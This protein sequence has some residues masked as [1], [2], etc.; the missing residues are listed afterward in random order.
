MFTYMEQLN[1]HKL[2]MNSM[3]YNEYDTIYN[4]YNKR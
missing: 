2:M 1:D 4:N 3:N